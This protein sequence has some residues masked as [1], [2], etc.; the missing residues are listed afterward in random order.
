M[1]ISEHIQG[2]VT[3]VKPEG[4][5]ADA[6]AE[7]LKQHLRTTSSRSLGR[8]ALDLSSVSFVDSRA[9]EV[10]VEAAEALAESGQSLKL[11]AASETLREVLD[12]TGLASKFEHFEDSHAAV[13]SFL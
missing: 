7:R 12:L 9:L 1:E 6:D 5:V 13:R 11:C 3:I 10:M 8:L 2:A 4:P